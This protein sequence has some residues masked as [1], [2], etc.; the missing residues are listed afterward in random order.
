MCGRPDGL[1]VNVSD[2][3]F[4]IIAL[5]RER[6]AFYVS[7]F[8]KLSSTRISHIS[9]IFSGPLAYPQDCSLAIR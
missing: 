8:T 9:H 7:V 4:D 5:L 2:Y 3:C 1:P 6:G